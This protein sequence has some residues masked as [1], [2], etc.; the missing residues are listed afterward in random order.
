[1]FGDFSDFDIEDFAFHETFQD[2]VLTPDSEYSLFWK[3]YL[4]AHPH[5]TDKILSARTLV[6][7]LKATQAAPPDTEFAHT[8]W[9]NIQQRTQPK[10]KTHWQ[11][12]LQWR[13]AASVALV[14]G[15]SVWW[16]QLEKST[17]SSTLSTTKISDSGLLEEVNRT[18]RTL[19]VH[20]SDGSVVHLGKD[21]RLTYPIQFAAEQRAVQLSGEAFFEI[22]KNP[23]RPFLVYANETVTKVLGTSFRVAAYA[24]APE[25]TV[26]VT[27]GR[28]SVFSTK[29]FEEES[30]K[31]QRTGVVLT[32]NQQAVF[33]R[34]HAQLNKT[35]V[36]TPALLAP[37]NQKPSFDFNSTPLREVFAVLEK[38]YGVEIV[39]DSDL[40]THRSLTV[41]MEDETLY[42]KLDVICKTLGLSYQ[43]VDA[44]VI[45][46]KGNS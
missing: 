32:P 30:T 14:I 44:K 9:Q 19:I 7:E 3:N 37:D 31:A 28:V 29:D 27:A 15:A 23:L 16:W 22:K 41:S 5:Q 34:K 46:E 8:I 43:I 20:L 38:A 21:S 26:A 17:N 45:V 10:I 24:D 1:M 40:T 18:D 35:L 36:P 6:L 2:W 42:E 4:A 12:L 33:Q 13:I 39:A 25:V 11:F